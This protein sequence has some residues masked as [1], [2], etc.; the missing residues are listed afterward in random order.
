MSTH[1]LEDDD[2][3]EEYDFSQSVRSPYAA[4]AGEVHF[5]TLDEDVY[6][7]FP[8]SQAVNEALRLLIKAAQGTRELPTA[9]IG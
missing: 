2:M 8:D 4:R 7:V 3:R 9:K 1:E 5:V 6:R